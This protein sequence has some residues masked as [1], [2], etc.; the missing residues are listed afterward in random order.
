MKFQRKVV[1]T[2]ALLV[3]FVSPALAVNVQF[4]STNDMHSRLYSEQD[5]KTREI[6]GG[7]ARLRTAVDVA[8]KEY[9]GDTLVVCG[10]DYFEGFFYYYFKGIPEVTVSNMLGYDVATIGNHEFDGG[11]EVLY[12]A[13]GV[14]YGSMATSAHVFAYL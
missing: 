14:V 6:V 2:V 13:D 3:L 7:F 5:P 11:A 12:V 4:L 8:K 9:K 10:G 1:L